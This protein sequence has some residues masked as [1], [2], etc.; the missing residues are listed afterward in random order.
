[1]PTCVT[2]QGAHAKIQDVKVSVKHA[3]ASVGALVVL[4]RRA[5]VPETLEHVKPQAAVD[6]VVTA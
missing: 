1:M 2:V 5:A 3:D 4:R 6:L